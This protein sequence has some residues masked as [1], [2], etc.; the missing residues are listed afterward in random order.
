MV[1]QNVALNKKNRECRIMKLSKKLI[2]S[3]FILI[4]LMLPLVVVQPTKASFRI[5]IVP[6]E[7]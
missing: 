2:V 7:Y 5:I 4:V 3:A 1:F 6:E